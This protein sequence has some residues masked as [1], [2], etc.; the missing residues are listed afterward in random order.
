MVFSLFTVLV[1]TDLS[2]EVNKKSASNCRT[3]TEKTEIFEDLADNDHLTV[4]TNTMH[5]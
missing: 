4:I 1:F 5:L 3:F 2:S